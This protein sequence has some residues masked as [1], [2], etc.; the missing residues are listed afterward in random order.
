M[1]T[2]PD[3]ALALS[4]ADEPAQAVIDEALLICY[5]NPTFKSRFLSQHSDAASLAD[6]AGDIAELTAACRRI[7]RD[8]Y[9]QTLSMNLADVPCVIECRQLM[10]DDH[11]HL[12]LTVVDAVHDQTGVPINTPDSQFRPAPWEASFYLTG[13]MLKHLDV[14]AM[15]IDVVMKFQAP[16]EH[17][18]RIFIVLAELYNNALDHG[19]LGLNSQMKTCASG[20]ADYYRE[21]DERLDKL[22]SG[23]IRITL[24][25]Q[26]VGDGGDIHIR[27]EDSGDGFDVEAVMLDA[28]VN[29]PLSGR[30]SQITRQLCNAFYYTH[31]GRVAHAIYR[32]MP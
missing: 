15:L 9:P 4:Q 27:V 21:R 24:Q 23:F 26:P 19:L 17:Q 22:S 3:Y 31:N 10:I 16:R 25:H 1:L 18:Q 8:H 20:F 32:W 29:E 30:G 11:F 14:T 2:P 6:I 28:M 12:G 5:A 7:Q 13:E